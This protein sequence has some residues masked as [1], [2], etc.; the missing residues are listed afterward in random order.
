MNGLQPNNAPCTLR[1]L[2]ERVRAPG[3]RFRSAPFWAWNAQLEER[4]LKWQ[5]QVFHEMGFGGFF[6]H[7]RVGLAT[8][9]LSQEWFRC[10]RFCVEEAKRLG[11]TAWL[12]DEDRWPSGA[13]GGLATNDDRFRARRLC[14][15]CAGVRAELPGY[16]SENVLGAFEIASDTG[17][18]RWLAELP[19]RA[20]DGGKLAVIYWKMLKD[21]PWFNGEAY[22]DTLNP[23]AVRRF[24]DITHEAY[25]RECGK[26]FGSAIPGIF[27]DEPAFAHLLNQEL[28]WTELL[29]KVFVET[30]GY[31]LLAH[32]PELFF[33]RKDQTFNR[34]RHD[35]YESCTE[36]F[37]EAFPRQIGEWCQAHRLVLTGHTMHEDL[38]ALQRGSC[39]AAMRFYEY[40]QVPGIDLL[41][42]YMDVIDSAKQCASV[43]RQLGRP[44]RLCEAYGCTGWDFPLAGHKAL[45]EWLLVLGINFRVPH[46]A[47]YSMEGEAK[48]DYP[49]SISFHSPWWRHYHA[50]EDHFARLNAALD[51]TVETRDLLVIHPIESCWGWKAAP[52]QE[53][54]LCYSK[55]LIA[56]RNALM[57][58]H[59]EFDYGD[60]VL[61]S[62]HARLDGRTLW[63]GQA[64]YRAVL[65]PE[66]AMIRGTTLELL[67]RFADAGG[68]VAYLGEPPTHLDACPCSLPA[69]IYARFHHV[70]T[71]DLA[72]VF[73][74]PV[75]RVSIVEKE[76]GREIDPI[77][78]TLREHPEGTLLFLVNTSMHHPDAM[79]VLLRVTERTLEY[80]K[81]LV[82]FRSEQPGVS[83]LYE[84]DTATGMWQ[85]RNAEFGGGHI[86]LSSSF[87]PLQ[88]RLFLATEKPLP[89]AVLSSLLSEDG[90]TAKVS[91]TFPDHPVISLDEPNVLVLDHA[92]YAVDGERLSDKPAYVLRI[93][94]ALR[95]RIGASVRGSCA[96]QAWCR[97]VPDVSRAVEATL[98]Y[99]FE[100]EVAPSEEKSLWLALEHPEAY[101]IEL[102]GVALTQEDGEWVDPCLRRIVVPPST[103]Q[104]GMNTLLLHTRFCEASPGLEAIFLLGDFGVLGERMITAPVQCLAC[105]DWCQQGLPN[106]SGNCVYHWQIHLP[107][108]IENAALRIPAWAGT[109]LGVSLDG[110]PLWLLAWP[111]YVVELGMLEAGAHTFDVTV[112]GSRRNAFGPFYAADP[113]PCRVGQRA[114]QVE[115]INWRRLE[116]SGLLALPE[117][118]AR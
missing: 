97:P 82:T 49:A 106:Y 88:S 35:Y 81:V 28:P 95:K 86:R 2:A 5:I 89:A 48:R 98:S 15:A 108:A 11:M 36:L 18:Y 51:G 63:V 112:F 9:Y 72:A 41:T 118:W 54:C 101:Y 10:V 56:L 21:D 43:A 102:N 16:P 52:T 62:R 17:E 40:E 70:Q 12:Y 25:Q 117:L 76:G 61:M 46:L 60:E 58:E 109:A 1:E 78:L 115:E 111:P 34:V 79:T 105:R 53:E 110:A 22:L 75:R 20:S 104:T 114:F 71:D 77:F 92:D 4:E 31:D 99:S 37:L 73:A 80:P 113:H 14:L 91:L 50:V 65:L 96:I 33:D 38:I 107:T 103:L 67:R 87:A 6:M 39:G 23:Q 45:G 47:W 30:H 29:P 3:H 116:P 13:A 7:A 83:H 94:E 57:R 93:D 100:C 27:T 32:L 90:G 69:E 26:D 84:L 55:G 74:L 66:M 44:R 64:N 8:R 85:E 19:E 42:E 59:L 68:L 24:L